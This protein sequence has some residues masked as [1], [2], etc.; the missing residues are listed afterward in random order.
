LGVPHAYVDAADL[1]FPEQCIGCGRPAETIYRME[2]R[3]GFDFIV[4]EVWE[5]AEIRLPIC[6]ACRKRRRLAGFATFGGWVLILPGVALAAYW[7]FGGQTMAAWILG[8]AVV[9]LVL[10]LR[11]AGHWLMD[12]A[13]FGVRARWLRGP[14]TLLRISLRRD[15]YFSE[16]IGLNPSATFS[17]A[18]PRL[19]RARVVEES[20]APMTFNRTLPALV[21]VVCIVA[22][23][24][25]HWYAVSRRT[26]MPAIVF[27]VPAVALLSLG[28]IVYPPIF[29][30]ISKDGRHLPLW[31]KICAGVLAAAGLAISCYLAFVVYSFPRRSR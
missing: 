16:W 22:L 10:T 4:A 6:A 14:G 8:S 5:F 30:S 23:A 17:S 20:Y 1:R 29:V 24:L 18:N 13:V 7:A 11:F 27:I 3:R 2:A 26:I 25:H 19:G 21:F 9:L 31:T 28:G 15:G 12:W